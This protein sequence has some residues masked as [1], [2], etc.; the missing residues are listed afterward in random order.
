MK[1]FRC[2]SCGKAGMWWDARCGVFLCHNRKCAIAIEYPQDAN[3]SSSEMKIRISLNQ[4]EV[5]QDTLDGSHQQLHQ[6]S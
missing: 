3:L 4:Y 6:L 1:I 2:P 5:S